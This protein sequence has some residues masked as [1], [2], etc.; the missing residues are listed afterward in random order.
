MQ[1]SPGKTAS[2][3]KAPF[4]KAKA[5]SAP[6]PQIASSSLNPIVPEAGH[7]T[8]PLSQQEMDLIVEKAGKFEIASLLELWDTHINALDKQRYHMAIAM[9]AEKSMRELMAKLLQK[10]TG[11][12]ENDQDS[13]EESEGSSAEDSGEEFED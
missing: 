2:S 8:K 12:P 9:T 5:S 10:D 1:Q 11:E 7:A 4:K 3:S 13:E 6:L